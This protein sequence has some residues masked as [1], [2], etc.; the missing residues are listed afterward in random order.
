MKG[1]IEL[2]EN[3]LEWELWNYNYDYL[4]YF[5]NVWLSLVTLNL[6]TFF[7]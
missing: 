7:Y 5:M 3:E 4:I 2:N 6:L 1:I